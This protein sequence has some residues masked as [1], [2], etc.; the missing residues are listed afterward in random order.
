M[1]PRAGSSSIVAR[2]CRRTV[3]ACLL[4]ACCIL[5]MSPTTAHALTGK[6][7][8]SRAKRW[9]ARRV[10]YSQCE[11]FGGYRTDC[12]GFVSMAWRLR[13]SYTTATLP[14]VSKRIPVSGLLPGDAVLMPGHVVIFTGW[15]SKSRGTYRTME[16]AGTGKPAL[17]RVRRLSGDDVGLRHVDSQCVGGPTGPEIVIRPKKLPSGR[18]MLRRLA[19]PAPRSAEPTAGAGVASAE[20][21]LSW[22]LA[23]WT[24]AA[25]SIVSR[26]VGLGGALVPDG[27]GAVR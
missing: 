18:R 17:S 10:P 7:V 2:P 19:L 9:V 24:P 5:T 4:I 20:D 15:V 3:A 13:G 26:R 23:E 21:V 27:D 1:D 6:R 12:S 8:V 14:S 11:Y 22:D 25:H 16:E